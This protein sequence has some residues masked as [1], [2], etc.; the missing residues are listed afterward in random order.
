MLRLQSLTYVGKFAF[1]Y[2]NKN[3]DQKVRYFGEFNLENLNI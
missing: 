3:Y 2:N 1:I